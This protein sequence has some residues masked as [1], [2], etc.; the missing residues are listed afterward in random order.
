MTLAA[1]P[2]EP[3]GRGYHRAMDEEPGAS[4]KTDDDARYEREQA[5]HDERFAD[6]QRPANRFYEVAGAAERHFCSLVD[7]LPPSSRVLDFGC[8]ADARTAI[9]LARVGHRVAAIDLSSVA[10][11]CARARAAEAGVGERIEFR[12]MNA[13]TLLFEDGFFDAVVGA[14]VLHHLDLRRSFAELVRVLAPDGRAVF[15][16]PMGHNP[17]INLYRRRT[18]EQRTPDEHPFVT[19]DIELAREYF[20][21]VRLTA[22]VLTSLAL[23]PFGAARRSK[24]LVDALNRLDSRLMRAVPALKGFAWLAVFEFEGP[25]RIE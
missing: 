15:S 11:E 4:T 16:E 12:T 25:R 22:F 7:A 9:R 19:A 17:V 1:Q 23:V 14:G 20:D 3:R 2:G 21:D 6:D 18:P 5:F 13:E 10:I 24:R 8:G